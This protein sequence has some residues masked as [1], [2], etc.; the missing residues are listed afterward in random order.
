MLKLKFLN[1]T[2]STDV[3]VFSSSSDDQRFISVMQMIPPLG[4]TWR[5]TKEPLEESEKGE[6]KSWLKAQ[7]SEN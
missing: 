2:Q 5:R 4:R 6:W 7:H 1:T 3:L